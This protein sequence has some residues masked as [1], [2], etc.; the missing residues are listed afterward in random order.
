MKKAMVSGRSD[1]FTVALFPL[2]IFVGDFLEGFKNSF[3]PVVPH[4]KSTRFDRILF[5]DK[6]FFSGDV[7]NDNIVGSR[8]A[9]V[10]VTFGDKY[11]G[12]SIFLSSSLIFSY[13]AG[14]LRGLQ[15]V[16]IFL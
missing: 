15:C 5:L 7:K 14:N 2:I 10:I 8:L 11:R 1:L 13:H 12:D 4:A 6:D 9:V 3:S 16:G